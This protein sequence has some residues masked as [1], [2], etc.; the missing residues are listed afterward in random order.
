MNKWAFRA[1]TSKKC[2]FFVI[3]PSLNYCWISSLYYRVIYFS[4]E[5]FSK[6]C[7]VD[8]NGY[9]GLNQCHI[10]FA[11]FLFLLLL[12]P[13][14]GP[15]Q[16]QSEHVLGN[17][18]GAICYSLLILPVIFKIY[19]SSG[20]KGGVFCPN[21]CQAKEPLESH[22]SQSVICLFLDYFNKQLNWVMNIR[23]SISVFRLYISATDCDIVKVTTI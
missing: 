11:S 21:V 2:S 4:S 13:H 6:V 5:C 1:I 20:C 18:T 7:P 8:L 15:E 3:V 22:F 19:S 16:V 17:C 10:D 23:V 12:F 14:I 9:W